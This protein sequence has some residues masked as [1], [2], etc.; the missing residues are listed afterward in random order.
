[1]RNHEIHGDIEA[2][3]RE[4]HARFEKAD[5]EGDVIG[6]QTLLLQ[7]MALAPL[8]TGGNAPR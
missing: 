5:A 1:M 2:V 6:A 3:F 4:A 7:M 8:V